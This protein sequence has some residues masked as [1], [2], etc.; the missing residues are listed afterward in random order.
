M[1]HLSNPIS[2]ILPTFNHAISAP[3]TSGRSHVSWGII[4]LTVYQG[5]KTQN[6]IR[7]SAPM[8]HHDPWTTLLATFPGHL[9]PFVSFLAVTARSIYQSTSIRHHSPPFM[10]LPTA[11]PPFSLHDQE[12]TRTSTWGWL[13]P[14]YICSASVS[15]PDTTANTLH[16]PW[17]FSTQILLLT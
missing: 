13:M 17:C 4:A 1:I 14:L 6:C 7:W 10:L 12:T 11:C 3:P 15:I 8:W 16:F 5:S 9:S 2:V